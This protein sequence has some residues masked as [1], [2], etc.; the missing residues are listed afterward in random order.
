MSNDVQ[1]PNLLISAFFWGI[2]AGLLG[3]ILMLLGKLI[4]KMPKSLPEKI[5]LSEKIN[6]FQLNTRI[7]GL[8]LSGKNMLTHE[9]GLTNNTRIIVIIIFSICIIIP[10]LIKIYLRRKERRT[11]ILA[12][13]IILILALLPVIISIILRFSVENYFQS[14]SIVKQFVNNNTYPADANI[15]SRIKLTIPVEAESLGQYFK[16]KSFSC[17]AAASLANNKKEKIILAD[18]QMRDGGRLPESTDIPI[19]DVIKPYLLLTIPGDSKYKGSIVNLKVKGDLLI[20]PGKTNLELYNYKIQTAF[21]ILRDSEMEFLN[22]SNEIINNFYFYI[23]ILFLIP[24]FI[25]ASVLIIRPKY[26]CGM[27]A[28]HVAAK[29]GNSEE[30]EKLL[31]AGASINAIDDDSDTPLYIA[32]KWGHSEIV[33]TLLEK[34]AN[35]NTVNKIKKTPLYIASENGHQSIVQLL[36]EAGA[37]VN[38]SGKSLAPIHIASLSGHKE[39]VEMLIKANA[40]INSVTNINVSPLFAASMNGHKHIVEILLQAGA[41]IN[42]SK[43]NTITPFQIASDNGFAEI[44]DILTKAGTN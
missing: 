21:R 16:V 1:K 11:T 30:T 10:V 12:K 31:Q 3:T 2:G 42:I 15:G 35:I 24:V 17:E 39:V 44:A 25:F 41:D 9:A 20:V 33:K 43:E 4:D 28:L 32:S 19:H 13:S 29:N 22:S 14:K 8:L 37:D 34:G 40:D 5:L 38:F 27:T 6:P 18:L 36:L 23:N 7:D 26:P